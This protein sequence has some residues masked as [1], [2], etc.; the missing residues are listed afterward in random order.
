MQYRSEPTP[1]PLSPSSQLSSSS[2]TSR[3]KSHPNHAARI[4]NLPTE[5]LAQIL[6]L[7]LILNYEMGE[8]DS[9]FGMAPLGQLRSVCTQWNDTILGEPAFWTHIA[10]ETGPRTVELK[11]LRSGSLP[12]T[13]RYCNVKEGASERERRPGFHRSMD[14]IG[15][16]THRWKSISFRA[17][18]RELDQL[19][20]FLESSPHPEMESLKIRSISVVADA[21]DWVCRDSASPRNVL[22]NGRALPRNSSEFRSLVNLGIQGAVGDLDLLVAVIQASQNLEALRLTDI[23]F[24]DNDVEVQQS[25]GWP[26]ESRPS[27]LPRL[28]DIQMIGFESPAAISCVLRCIRVPNIT[29]LEIFEGRT[30][31]AQRRS[32]ITRA[33]TT[34]HGSQSI[35]TSMFHNSSALA[36]VELRCFRDTMCLD[37]KDPTQNKACLLRLSNTHSW[38]DWQESAVMIGE[39]ARLANVAI[40]LQFDWLPLLVVLVVLESFPTAME[41]EFTGWNLP[42]IDIEYLLRVMSQPINTGGGIRRWMCPQLARFRLPRSLHEPEVA[43]IARNAMLL[44]QARKD[45]NDQ[46]TRE[47]NIGDS[48]GIL[49]E[50]RVLV[51]ELEI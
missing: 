2:V 6:L 3:E 23:E 40:T 48:Y 31:V 5:L 25:L 43:E 22:F 12:L 42:V 11:L 20:A 51:G 19:V 21:L 38:T 14:L 1:S 18:N 16:H 4:D 7:S 36:A 24:N 50:V 34:H 29:A 41:L 30:V 37:F 27:I 47:G 8:D 35:L 46:K 44:K 15:R 49:S 17:S 13:I 9:L 10:I 33:L 32:Q 39:V 45:F 28:S 26:D